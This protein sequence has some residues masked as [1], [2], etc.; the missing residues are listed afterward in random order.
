MVVDVPSVDGIEQEEEHR[1][2]LPGMID[3][4]VAGE[5]LPRHR[6][7]LLDHL[8]DVRLAQGE[9]DPRVED[10]HSGVE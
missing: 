2:V 9:D 8:A 6:L 3:R 1:S 10:M 5:H 4:R 7:Q